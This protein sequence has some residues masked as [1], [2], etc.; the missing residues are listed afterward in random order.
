MRNKYSLFKSNL[1]STPHQNYLVNGMAFAL[2]NTKI[3][4][5]FGL[6]DILPT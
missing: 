1:F 3:S 4:T 6:S 2:I 5:Y